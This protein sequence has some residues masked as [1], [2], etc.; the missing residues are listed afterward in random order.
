MEAGL[1]TEIKTRLMNK[2]G[3]QYESRTKEE[4][5]WVRGQAPSYLFLT[6]IALLYRTILYYGV[7]KDQ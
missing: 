6:V 1:Y 2:A 3:G 7:H 4:F 5:T